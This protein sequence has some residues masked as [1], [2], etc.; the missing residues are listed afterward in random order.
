MMR[1]ACLVVP[2]SFDPTTVEAKMLVAFGGFTR[3]D[4]L[5][6]WIAPDK[7]VFREPVFVYA[8]AMEDT[9]ANLS[10]LVALANYV[11]TTYSQQCVYVR[12]PDGAI[13]FI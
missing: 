5:G 9:D 8:L 12:K 4:G 3:T 7:H 6:G 1:E 11:K 13:I 10:E 2:V